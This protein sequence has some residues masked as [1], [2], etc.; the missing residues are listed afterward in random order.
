MHAINKAKDSVFQSIEGMDL[1]NEDTSSS[2]TANTEIRA[3]N[4]SI[5]VDDPPRENVK[6]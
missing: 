5:S 3:E 2:S 6:N 4:I 1:E